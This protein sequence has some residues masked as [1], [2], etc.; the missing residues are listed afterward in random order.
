MQRFSVCN[1]L[2]NFFFDLISSF[3]VF[4]LLVSLVVFHL[5]CFASGGIFDIALAT[6]FMGTLFVP[7][8]I[9]LIMGFKRFRFEENKE[10]VELA[11]LEKPQ[12]VKIQIKHLSPQTDNP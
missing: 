10:D 4:C 6:A 1:H 8:T 9:I 12:Q 5:I 11:Y 3:F 2:F 7:A